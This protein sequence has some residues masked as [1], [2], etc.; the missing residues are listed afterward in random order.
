MPTASAVI[1]RINKNNK[2]YGT[3]S[4]IQH[5][6]PAEYLFGN[7]KQPKQQDL[8][9]RQALAKGV[10]IPNIIFKKALFSTKTL[11]LSGHSFIIYL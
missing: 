6:H 9:N 2:I 10:V 7:L 5:F 11:I 3:F 1:I 4:E 8:V